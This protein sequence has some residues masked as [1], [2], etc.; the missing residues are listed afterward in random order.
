MACSDNVVRAGLTP[1]HKHVDELLSML[2]YSSKPPMQH[3]MKP[4]VLVAAP[5]ASLKLFAPP[6]EFPE[7]CLLQCSVQA[8]ASIDVPLPYASPY[9]LLCLQVP[10]PPPFFSSSP[11]RRFLTLAQGKAT[12]TI[13]PPSSAPGGG[14]SASRSIEAL[15]ALLL[16]PVAQSVLR[17]DAE[18]ETTLYASPRL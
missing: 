4:E 7:F 17:V 10:S 6:P 5:H 16:A 13:A 2:L 18:Q 12:V 14:S 3:H 11:Y 8:H 15:R 9:I 1:K